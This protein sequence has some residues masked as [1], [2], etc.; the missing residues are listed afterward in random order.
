MLNKKEKEWIIEAMKSWIR[1][2]NTNRGICD[3]KESLPNWFKT[4]KF[5]DKK[6]IES[7]Y[8]KMIR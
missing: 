1:G 4:H 7:I 3:D 5:P 2:K 8:R 6:I